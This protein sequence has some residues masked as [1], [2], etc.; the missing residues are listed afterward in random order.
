MLFAGLLRSVLADVPIHLGGVGSGVLITLQQGGLAL[1]VATLGTVYLARAERSTARAFATVEFV[2]M[3]IIAL[4]A[5]VITVM[6]HM[7]FP[8]ITVELSILHS[9]SQAP[10]PGKPVR[11]RFWFEPCARVTM[12]PAT[13]ALAAPAGRQSHQPRC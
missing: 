4:I 7:T 5:I 9:A 3:A 13:A 10:D 8:A 1:G 11:R 2:Q 12:G 6:F